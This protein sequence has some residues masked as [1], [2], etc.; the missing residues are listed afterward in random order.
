MPNFDSLYIDYMI[1]VPCKECGNHYLFAPFKNKNDFLTAL[2]ELCLSFNDGHSRGLLDNFPP[3]AAI[4]TGNAENE[5]NI[6]CFSVRDSHIKPSKIKWI[7]ESSFHSIVSDD[8][9]KGNFIALLFQKKVI[10][11]R[12][13]NMDDFYKE[14]LKMVESR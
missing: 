3:F 11:I 10:L 12:R 1:A 8:G 5:K 13:K 4:T 2:E 9:F 7:G 6:F 14:C